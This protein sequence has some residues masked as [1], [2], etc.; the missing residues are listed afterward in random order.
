LGVATH[1]H[2]AGIRSNR[3]LATPGEYVN[4]PCTHRN[5]CAWQLIFLESENLS[6]IFQPNVQKDNLANNAGVIW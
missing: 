2:D 5:K 6:V 4:A 1:P 3:A